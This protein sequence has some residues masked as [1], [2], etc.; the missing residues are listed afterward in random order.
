MIHPDTPRARNQKYRL[1]G[2][3]AQLL[4]TKDA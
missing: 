1:T 3:G 4:K 2:R